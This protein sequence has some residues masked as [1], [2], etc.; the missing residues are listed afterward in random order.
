MNAIKKG[1]ESDEKIPSA[2]EPLLFIHFFSK[3]QRDVNAF[4]VSEIKSD[5]EKILPYWKEI[6]RDIYELI[7]DIKETTL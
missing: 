7:N 1:E 6:L 2:I 4:L 3:I 5:S